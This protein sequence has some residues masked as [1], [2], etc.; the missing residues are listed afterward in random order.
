[1]VTLARNNVPNVD[2]RVMDVR[3]IDQ[4][5]CTYDA[6]VAAFVLPFLSYED[7]E[8]LIKSIGKLLNTKGVV[9]L[10]TIEGSAEDNGFETTSFSGKSEIH[11]VYYE[12]PLLTDMF[13]KAGIRVK[14]IRK[15][16]YLKNSIPVLTDIILLGEK[17]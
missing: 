6:I 2:F 9:Y 15:Q 7:S 17:E 16:P 8:K 5:T 3:T 14:N 4:F 1:M 10:S 13:R 11:F 12:V